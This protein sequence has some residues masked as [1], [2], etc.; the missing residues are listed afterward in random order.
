MHLS[1]KLFFVFCLSL[2]FVNSQELNGKWLKLRDPGELTIP[3]IEVVEF[4]KDSLFHYDF[5]K[6]EQ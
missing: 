2:G 1:Y 6:F 4:K 5:N 3:L